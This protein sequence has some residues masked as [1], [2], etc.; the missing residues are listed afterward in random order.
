MRPGTTTMRTAAILPVK[1]FSAAKQR[2]GAG[3][4][5]ALRDALVR[6]MLA[7]V[8]EAL[9]ATPAIELTIIVSRQPQLPDWEAPGVMV[10]EDR[11]EQGQSAAASLGVER[12]LHDGFER[13][14]CVPGDCPALSPAELQEL[15]GDPPADRPEVVIVPDRHGSGTNGLLLAPPDAI[16]P[17]FG[18]GSFERHR[19]LVLAGGAALRVERPPSLLLDIDTDADLQALR[20]RLAESTGGAGRTRA[21]LAEA[22]AGAAA[23]PG[24]R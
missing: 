12:A 1:R 18:P 9:T 20:R 5:E 23:A 4:Q 3:V 11:L 21:L 7:D 8:L 22:H 19:S 15:L 2:L 13:V 14:L 17:S 6:T 10:V 24:R 16:A